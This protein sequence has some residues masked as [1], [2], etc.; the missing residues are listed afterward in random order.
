MTALRFIVPN[1]N[2]RPDRWNLCR[3]SLCARGI[4][5]GGWFISHHYM[6]PFKDVPKALHEFPHLTPRKYRLLNAWAYLFI[7]FLIYSPYV[8]VLCNVLGALSGSTIAR[9]LLS[10][11]LSTRIILVQSFNHSAHPTGILT[12]HSDSRR[13]E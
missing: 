3:S 2:R 7:P 1:F 11:S 4:P 12:E 8:D 6:P 9:D 10:T 5:A 13:K